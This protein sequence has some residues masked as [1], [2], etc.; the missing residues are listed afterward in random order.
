MT[1]YGTRSPYPT[2]DPIPDDVLAKWQN[3]VDV[4][5]EIVQVPAGLIMRIDGAHIEVFKSSR[6]E[7]N[8]Y[9]PGDKPPESV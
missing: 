5:A 6:S 1:D 2:P 9:E 7:G 3:V 4:M 8:P